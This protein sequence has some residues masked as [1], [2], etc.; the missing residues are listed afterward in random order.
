MP[1]N[2]IKVDFNEYLDVKIPWHTKIRVKGRSIY[3]VTLRD[4]V[5]DA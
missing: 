3:D 1:F 5:Q 4:T 2:N